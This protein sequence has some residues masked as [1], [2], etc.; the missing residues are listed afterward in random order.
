MAGTS[1][2]KPSLGRLMKAGRLEATPPLTQ[3]GL[4]KQVGYTTA[5]ISKIE[6]GT[7]TPPPD[8]VRAIAAALGQD[9]E[10][11]LAAATRPSTIG[12]NVGAVGDAVRLAQENSAR[13]KEIK[14]AV[15]ELTQ[16]VEAAAK[17]YDDEVGK[18]RSE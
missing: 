14:R 9:E 3:E 15:A 12:G 10:E 7:R 6:A 11:F 2:S 5:M 16:K 8:R 18:C 1:P 13:G 4:A 17:A